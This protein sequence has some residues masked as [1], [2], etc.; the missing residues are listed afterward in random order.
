MFVK[1]QTPVGFKIL[2][3]FSKF[4]FSEK[5]FKVTFSGLDKFMS[6]EELKINLNTINE[7]TLHRSHKST[8]KNYAHADVSSLLSIQKIKEKLEGIKIMGKSVKVRVKELDEETIDLLTGIY[9]GLDFNKLEEESVEY[10][11]NYI[12][13][14]YIKNMTDNPYQVNNLLSEIE[15]N[16]DLVE[17]ANF[18]RIL[19]DMDYKLNIVSNFDIKSLS[20]KKFV[21]HPTFLPINTYT[22]FGDN[23]PKEQEK[24]K[25]IQNSFENMFRNLNYTSYEALTNEGAYR[26]LQIKFIN[27]KGLKSGNFSEITNINNNCKLKENSPSFMIT[28]LLAACKLSEIDLKIITE[29]I[30][31]E[32]KDFLHY[33]SFYIATNEKIQASVQ[34]T[35]IFYHICGTSAFMNLVKPNGEEIKILPI[36]SDSVPL[37][38]KHLNLNKVF[39]NNVFDNILEIDFSNNNL[40]LARVLDINYKHNILLLND[41]FDFGIYDFNTR[42]T[43]L[44]R[45]SHLNKIMLFKQIYKFEE[46]MTNQNIINSNNNLLIFNLKNKNQQKLKFDKIKNNAKFHILISNSLVEILDFMKN[47]PESPKLIKL[48][49][50]KDIL[51]Q[52]RDIILIIKI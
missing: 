34:N 27:E 42:E 32:F 33:C 16:S 14:F 9:G 21:N 25:A 11:K 18:Q 48:Y 1:M 10:I 31:F 52:I 20:K 39:E 51:F 19:F 4:L 6:N 43:L 5:F 41:D 7:I 36:T 38:I 8:N 2:F 37:S 3:H 44:T 45:K 28:L 13:S 50:L 35:Q 12:K 47:Y 15:N 22:K 49:I 17:V 30:K 29:A 46:T 23:Y 26:N 24:I 40:P